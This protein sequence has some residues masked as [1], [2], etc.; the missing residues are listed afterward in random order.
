MWPKNLIDDLADTYNIDVFAPTETCISLN[1]TSAKL[2]DAIPHGFT[3]I[4]TPRL[5]PDSCTS[6]IVSGDTAFLL[7][8]LCKS[9]S[10][11]NYCF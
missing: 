5:V 8:K 1:T 9:L 4:S 7:R 10:T 2:Y 3:F 6:P 11:P